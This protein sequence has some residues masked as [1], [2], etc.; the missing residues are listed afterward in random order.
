M[1]VSPFLALCLAS[2]G[3]YIT[4]TLQYAIIHCTHTT[5]NDDGAHTVK[6]KARGRAEASPARLMLPSLYPQ[7]HP[8]E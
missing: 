8:A 2:D 4:Q 3:I 5:G 1:G 6:R 7:L